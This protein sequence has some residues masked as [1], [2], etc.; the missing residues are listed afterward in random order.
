MTPEQWREIKEVLARAL[1]LHPDERAGYLDVACADHKGMRTEVDSLVKS[2]E[3]DTSFLA[4]PAVET[5]GPHVPLDLSDRLSGSRFGAYEVLEIIGEGGMG[6]VYRA[7][8]FDGL[9]DK[10]VAIKI[11]RAELPGRFFLSRFD[12]ERRILARLEHPNIARLLDGGVTSEGLPFLVLEFVDGTPIDQYCTEHALSIPQR[13]ELFRTVCAA[14]QYAHQN[15]VVHRDLKPANILV[16]SAAVPKLLDFGVAKVLDPQQDESQSATTIAILRILTPDFASPEQVRGD[17]ITIASDVYS[18]GVIL[19]LLLTGE[20]PYR[21][22]GTGPQ[23]VIDTVCNAI[24]KKPSA[25]VGGTEKQE[26]AE[27]LRRFVPNSLARTLRGDLDCILLKALRKEP[28]QRYPTVAEFSDD[29]GRYLGRV[30]VKARKGTNAYRLSRFLARNRGG[31]IVAMMLLAVLLTGTGLILREGYLAQRR[32]ND[33]RRL[34][35]SLI[36]EIHDSIKGLPGSTP[37]RKLIVD[38]ALEYLDNLSKQSSGDLSLK[39][40]LATAYERV[41][42]VQGQFLQ[43]S[44]GDTKGSLASYEKAFAIR[45]WIADKTGDYADRLALAQAYRLVGTQQW[46]LG[47]YPL[48]IQNASSALVISEELNRSRPD[49]WETLKE[50]GRD[51][52][53]AGA[54]QGRGYGGGIGDPQKSKEYYHKAMAISETMLRLRP[55][56][57]ETLDSYTTDLYHRG[58]EVRGQDPEA[59]LELFQKELSISEKLMQRSPDILYARQTARSYTDLSITF[60]QMGDYRHG[61]E[62][63]LH[64]LDIYKRILATDPQNSLLKRGTAVAYINTATDYRQLGRKTESAEYTQPA[65]QLTRE[66]VRSDSSNRQN[67]GLM[68]AMAVAAAYNFMSIGKPDPAMREF[69]EGCAIYKSI[70][71]ASPSEPGSLAKL[72][73]CDTGMGDAARIAGNRPDAERFYTQAIVRG[74]CLNSNSPDLQMCVAAAHAY[75]GMG[76]LNRKPAGRKSAG[77]CEETREWY[78]K[79]IAAWEKVSHP[80]AI[81]KYSFEMGSA[82]DV[83]KKLQACVP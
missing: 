49:D 12:T 8:R 24:P 79:S 55:D 3:E 48:A 17:P 68:A 38:R 18:L 26:P 39:R 13:L 60:D 59:A 43:V 54:F 5:F 66:L 19:Y 33:V 31:V 21:V 22:P 28:E 16:T 37:A 45:K 2:Y 20:H 73:Y 6:T 76:D 36:F 29:I 56:D 58:E 50:L 53:Y 65:L 23:Q 40:E 75:E 9:Y 70:L 67:Q 71:N 7:R 1:E 27:D 64:G 35:N 77:G 25:V 30:P 80:G 11:I 69:E 44:L 47:E 42:L 61:L 46:A 81:N 15:L 34:A 62:S 57:L 72:A 82:D 14:L 10:Q 63:D 52:D 32:F 78:E 83:K 51:Y 41:G 74:S 4:Q